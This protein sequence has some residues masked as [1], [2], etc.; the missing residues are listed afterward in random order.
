M[1]RTEKTERY[2]SGS[3]EEVINAGNGRSDYIDHAARGFMGKLT[4]REYRVPA[5]DTGEELF[6][7]NRELLARFTS[8]TDPV[9]ETLLIAIRTI[10][11]SEDVR[12]LRLHIL[13]TS[14]RKRAVSFKALG[15]LDGP[16]DVRFV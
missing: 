16:M 5:A 11:R 6:F 7:N 14:T 8:M 9:Q 10:M 13:W 1:V 3:L 12:E 4:G 2:V 15:K